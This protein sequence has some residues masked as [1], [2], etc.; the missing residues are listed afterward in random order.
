MTKVE[1]AAKLRPGTAWNQ[2]GDVLEQATDDAPRVS[3]PS[4][5]EL[6]AE[7]AKT[8]YIE[9]RFKEYPPFRDFADAYFHDRKGNSGPMTDYLAK[10]QS[11]KDKYPKPA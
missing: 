9:K 10:I 7:I 4:E 3:I 2:R 11:I 6:I 1:A 5:G 8:A